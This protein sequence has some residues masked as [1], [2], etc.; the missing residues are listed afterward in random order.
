MQGEAR[1]NKFTICKVLRV[2]SVAYSIYLSIYLSIYIYIELTFH[3]GHKRTFIFTI[4][5]NVV[6][7]A[8]IYI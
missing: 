7:N 5:T 1:V 8:Y 3:S 4:F 2:N 6:I